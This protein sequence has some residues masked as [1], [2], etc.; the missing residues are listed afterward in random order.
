DSDARVVLTQQSLLG[1]LPEGG[2]ARV[3]LDTDWP[4]IA[5]QSAENSSGAAGPGNLAYVMY[6]SGSTGTPKGVEIEHH[7]TVALLAWA[8]ERFDNGELD[9]VLASTSICFDLSVFEIFAPLAWGG[10]VILSRDALQLPELPAASEVKLVNTVP[11]A[12]AE[13]LRIGGL[14]GSVSTINLA[15]EPL[16]ASLVA[17]IF[18]TGQGRRVFDLYGPTEDTTYSTCAQR[19]AEGPVTIGRPISNKRVYLFDG[20]LQPVPIGVSGDL[21]V[22]G[23]GVARGYRKRPEMTAEKFL[24]DPFREGERMYRTGDRGRFLSDGQ[25]QFLGRTDHQVKIRGYRIEIGEIEQ[26]LTRHP[27][28]LACAVAA[29]E[30]KPGDKRLVGYVVSRTG[31]SPSVMELR[32]Y[33]KSTL[34]DYMV[35]STFVFLDALPLTPNGKLDR[36]AL[37]APEQTRPELE[38]VFVAPRNALEQ[39]VARI[40]GQVLGLEKV[41]VHDNFFELG[42]HSLLATLVFARLQKAFPVAPPLRA[43]FEKPTVAELSVAIEELGQGRAGSPRSPILPV[44]RQALSREPGFV[45]EGGNLSDKP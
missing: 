21:Y 11:S 1:G 4:A 9:G 12:M 14:P 36:R 31:S 3:C 23:A 10:K 2:F 39:T 25:I 43:L 45:S 35:P 19:T 17:E 37:P 28:I 8:R 26:A 42:G 38:D 22:A 27:E 20:R 15:G 32:G 24:A 30:E 33:L 7:S 44:S 34:P 5:G 13:L 40:W 16:T 18:E 41:G 6:T 29:R